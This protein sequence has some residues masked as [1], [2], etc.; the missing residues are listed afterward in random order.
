MFDLVEN[1]ECA[2]YVFGDEKFFYYVKSCNFYLFY[3]KNEIITK[4]LAVKNFSRKV[5]STKLLCVRIC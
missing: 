3:D 5:L 1:E 2:L 4:V